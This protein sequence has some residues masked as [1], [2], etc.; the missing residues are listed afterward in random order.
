M[1]TIGAENLDSRLTAAHRFASAPPSTL[2][3][4]QEAAALLC[5]SE[6]KL[7]RDRWLKTGIPFVQ[8]GRAVRYKLSDIMDAIERGRQTFTMGYAFNFTLAS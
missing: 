5:V 4:T 8:I 3:T 6:K 2:L 1:E 7:V